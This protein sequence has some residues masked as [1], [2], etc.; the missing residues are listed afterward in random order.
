MKEDSKKIQGYYIEQ[1][2]F[3]TDSCT[4]TERY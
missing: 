3:D 2:S 4:D 1:Q